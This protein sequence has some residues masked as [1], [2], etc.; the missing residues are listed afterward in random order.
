MT[1]EK[2]NFKQELQDSV[3]KTSI[4]PE[5]AEAFEKLTKVADALNKPMSEVSTELSSLLKTLIVA[6]EDIVASDN[7][8]DF[9]AMTQDASKH[10]LTHEVPCI[11][12]ADRPAELRLGMICRECGKTWSCKIS[13]VKKSINNLKPEVCPQCGQAHLME[14]EVDKADIMERAIQ[15]QEGKMNIMNVINGETSELTSNC[16]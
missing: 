1:D 3:L 16:K 6:H 4:D 5:Y 12:W 14:N 11:L 2:I 9:V 13:N 7:W 8:D 15:S 10:R